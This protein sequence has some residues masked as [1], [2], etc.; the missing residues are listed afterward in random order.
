MFDRGTNSCSTLKNF[1][2]ISYN[3]NFRTQ[4]RGTNSCSCLR[5]YS[6][7]NDILLQN[8]MVSQNIR[9]IR[10][11]TGTPGNYRFICTRTSY[12]ISCSVWTSDVLTSESDSKSES[13]S[14][15]SFV[16]QSSSGSE[17]K[18]GS[19][20]QGHGIAGIISSESESESGSVE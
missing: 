11:I 12:V 6:S 7:F 2:I 16:C 19:G 3:S 14:V 9:A 4:S 8:E 1:H 17:S 18:S 5:Y 20:D 15:E 10:N 13:E